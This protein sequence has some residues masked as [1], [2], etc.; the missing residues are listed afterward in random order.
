M[1]MMCKIPPTSTA[2]IPTITT[3]TTIPTIMTTTSQDTYSTAR[4]S[5]NFNTSFS[6]GTDLISQEVS[7]TIDGCKTKNLAN[8]SDAI[9]NRSQELTPTLSNAE[10]Q[11][12]DNDDADPDPIWDTPKQSQQYKNTTVKSLSKNEQTDSC[13]VN[14][15][16]DQV[17]SQQK[18]WNE[19]PSPAN[20]AQSTTKTWSKV[21]KKTKRHGGFDRNHLISTDNSIGANDKVDLIVEYME[22]EQNNKNDE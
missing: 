10:Q 15:E 7:K 8:T 19:P 14:K 20:T 9:V 11:S 17:H 5:C 3:T 18:K 22:E 6:T 1:L 13:D 2:T 4:N 16:Q 12:D 21:K